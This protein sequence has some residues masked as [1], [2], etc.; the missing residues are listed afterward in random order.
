[1]TCERITFLIF[2]YQDNVTHNHYYYELDYQPM[3]NNKKK[4]LNLTSEFISINSRTAIAWVT[5]IQKNHNI[6]GAPISNP[7]AEYSMDIGK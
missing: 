6:N 2:V 3:V 1:M 7:K 5:V 4:I